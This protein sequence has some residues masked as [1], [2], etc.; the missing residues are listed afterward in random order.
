MPQS[1]SQP[2]DKTDAIAIL[3]SG[4][5]I[6]YIA[7]KAVEN[8]RHEFPWKVS[9]FIYSDQKMKFQLSAVP[10]N[11]DRI[12]VFAEILILDMRMKP[13]VM[14]YPLVP[15]ETLF[16]SVCCV[17]AK[18]IDSDL[19]LKDTIQKHMEA[20]LK[21]DFLKKAVYQ[22]LTLHG[23]PNYFTIRKRAD[24]H[25]LVDFEKFRAVLDTHLSAVREQGNDVN[26]YLWVETPL[27][28]QEGF[29]LSFISKAQGI[30]FL[31]IK[32]R[33]KD[34]DNFIYSNVK[35]KSKN[36]EQELF[37]MFLGIIEKLN[38]FSESVLQGRAE[39][40]YSFEAETHIPE[41]EPD[42]DYLM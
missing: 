8:Y 14:T 37:V 22:V 5:D 15:Y 29:S 36:S 24:I 26:E 3:W 35:V 42:D 9:S 13:S 20:Y 11:Q 23:F 1:Q 38:K 33:T 16:S 6:Q 18:G 21:S 2:Q 30:T 27:Q 25:V 40:S 34:G 31:R 39:K 17:Y 19:Y 4:T 28:E 41:S 10:C 32:A 7:D 12:L